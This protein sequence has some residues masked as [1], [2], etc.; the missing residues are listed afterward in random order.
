MK[1]NKLIRSTLAHK[2]SEDTSN[3]FL[4]RLATNNG[5]VAVRTMIKQ[6]ISCDFTCR[7]LNRVG[8]KIIDGIEQI[9]SSAAQ[10]PVRILR[11]HLQIFAETLD[12]ALLAK[13]RLD[14]FTQFA[15]KFR[16]LIHADSSPKPGL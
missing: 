2:T 3:F 8:A 11:Q 6:F 16:R 15:D 13:M 14:I 5:S 12:H 7:T 9:F 4:N 10:Q 1:Q